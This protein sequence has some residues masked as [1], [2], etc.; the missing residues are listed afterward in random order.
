MRLEERNIQ[1]TEVCLHLRIWHPEKPNAKNPIFLL[2]H[3]LSSNAMT[4]DFVAQHL[5]QAG[6]LAA[7][8]DQRGH[9]LSTKPASGYDFSTITSDLAEL[10][11]ELGYQDL[12][13][14]GQSWGG[15]VVLEAGAR[16]PQ[17]VKGLVFVDGGFLQISTR[18]PWEEVSQQL[19]PPDLAGIPRADL[20][21]RIGRMHPTWVPDGVEITL[22]NFEL[23]QDGTI[24]P[25][26]SREN[27][28]TILRALYDQDVTTLFPQIQVPVLICP[29]DDGSELSKK[30]RSW[31]ETAA[32]QIASAS[33]RWFEGAAHD[34][35]VDRPEELASELIEFAESLT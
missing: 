2:L 29:A 21:E 13:L 32:R 28:M 31:V 12:I 10:V 34:I 33:V 14:A 24:R 35:H 18:G 6:Y 4:W 30:K 8:V 22:G 16:Y 25:W 1:L 7:A 19:S 20:A 23:L 11:A 3:G 5:A 17:M 26:L 15:N 27:H 9:G